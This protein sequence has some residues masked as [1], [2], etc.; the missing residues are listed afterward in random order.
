M[1]SPRVGPRTLLFLGVPFGVLRA[2][3]VTSE[4]GVVYL[5]GGTGSFGR[6][7]IRHL[8][9][10]RK[11]DKVISVSRNAEMRYK[12]EADYPAWIQDGSLVVVPGDVRHRCDLEASY[13]G[14]IDCIVHA[15]AEK[16]VGTGESHK[17]YVVDINV[18]GAV[19]VN[20]FAAE[21][22]IRVVALSTDK[23]CAP[24]NV[25][26]A[27]KAI[28]EKVFTGAGHTVV[29]YG[30]VAG[31]SGSVIPLFIRQMDEKRITVTDRSMTRF[32]MP[33]TPESDVQVF[34][35]DTPAISAV[36]F[37]EYALRHPSPGNILVPRI[38]STTV[39]ELADAFA[40]RAIGCKV[41]EVGVRPGEKI[42]EDLVSPE[43]G[44]RCYHLDGFLCIV[45]E[46][47]SSSTHGRPM[48]PCSPDFSYASNH[49]PRTLVLEVPA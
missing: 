27:T 42:H 8:L 3:V 29:R 5:T 24:I 28:A 39:G 17:Q 7:M 41:I 31:S 34:L 14:T 11:A 32:F 46:T 25:Y 48:E 43:E 16:H 35:G 1:E 13:E 40:Q 23:A 33:L 6:A 21:R 2:S 20:S 22:G 47:E 15:A 12:L 4:F 44:R 18:G 9:H 36:G 30:N 10:G 26:G 38:P 37:V 19:N 49:D 45:P